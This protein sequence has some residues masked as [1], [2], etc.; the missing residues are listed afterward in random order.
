MKEK[1]VLVNLP[2]LMVQLTHNVSKLNLRVISTSLNLK[3]NGSSAP[4]L[5][6]QLFPVYLVCPDKK[7]HDYIR[8]KQDKF[9]EGRDMKPDYLMKCARFKYK[10][11][12]DKGDWEAPDAQGKEILA[13]RAEINAERQVDHV[14]HQMR[15]NVHM[16]LHQDR[17]PQGQRVWKVGLPRPICMQR[18]EQKQEKH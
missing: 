17:S 10:I 11:L 6:H 3:R 12:L 15:K 1:V 7:F 2:E 8:A 4:D 9:E 16:V 13:V 18:M 5:L 14:A